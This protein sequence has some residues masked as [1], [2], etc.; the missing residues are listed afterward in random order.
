MACLESRGRAARRAGDRG[1]VQPGRRCR[2]R[3]CAAAARQRV[4]GPACTQRPRAHAA[5]PHRRGEPIMNLTIRAIGAPLDRIDGP[6]K[7]TGTA[8]YAFEYPLAAVTSA[9]PGPRTI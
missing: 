8:T 4:Q 2:T 5:R 7:L 6:K 3:R 9:F 1:D